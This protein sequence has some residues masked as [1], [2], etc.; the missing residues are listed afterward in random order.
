MNFLR[1]FNRSFWVSNFMELFERM[2]FYGMQ[3]VLFFYLTGALS[4]GCLGFPKD[5]AG[6][7]MGIFTLFLW[8]LPIFGGAFAERYGYRKTF[9][10]A[11]LLLSAGYFSMGMVRD[12]F[13]DPSRRYWATV[14]ALMLVSV[15]GALFKPTLTGTISRTTNDRTSSMGFGIYYML[16]NI[17]AYIG[18]FVASWCRARDWRLVFFASAAWVFVMI[19]LAVALYKEPR[20]PREERS[21]KGFGKVIADSLLVVANWRFMV[22][23][24]IY[25]G[26]WI[27]FWQLFITM[28]QYLREFVNTTPLLEAVRNVSAALHGW[29]VPG[30]DARLAE[31]AA[32]RIRPGDAVPPE[33]LTNLEAFSIMLFQLLVSRISGFF[34]PFTA[35]IAGILITSC[36]MF[37][38]AFT[39]NPW[40]MVLAIMLLAVGEMSVSPKFM[41]YVG[42]IAPKNQVALF[43]GYGFL[44]I[45][46]GS[47]V[48]N[49]LGGKLLKAVEMQT[50]TTTQMWCTFGGIGLVTVLAMGLYNIYLAPSLAGGREETEAPGNNN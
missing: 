19:F 16:V 28:S 9:V 20:D 11:L 14:G 7:L 23:I 15:G 26:F 39:A 4:E 29:W 12:A 13:A 10:I 44:P 6:S 48:A 36:S 22:L 24:L 34:R 30:L 1:Q 8:M 32:G 46:I 49:N 45:G 18:P 38:P 21:S 25:S 3:G 33:L 5:N 41:E 43:L 50:R 31:V 40:M 42:K 27:C 2:A 37:I 35:M 17:G 47:Y